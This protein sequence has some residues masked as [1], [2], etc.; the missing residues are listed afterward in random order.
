MFDTL[1]TF[2]LLTSLLKLWA[3]LNTEGEEDADVRTGKN[4]ASVTMA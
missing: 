4:G 1:A 3:V 2:H